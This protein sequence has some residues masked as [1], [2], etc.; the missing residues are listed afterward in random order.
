MPKKI[1]SKST[2]IG[3][4]N[5]LIKLLNGEIQPEESDLNQ[6]TDENG[7][8]LNNLQAVFLTTYGKITAD[9]E[10]I[11]TYENAFEANDNNGFY[12]DL[13]A[14]IGQ[15]N[16]IIE[17]YKE[18]DEEIEIIDNGRVINLKNVKISN[19]S[20]P[21]STSYY[22]QLILFIDQIIGFSIHSQD[23]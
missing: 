14:L 8:P 3:T 4:L 16:K 11:V 19:V 22:D 2:L 15:R 23:N 9:I 21:D 1:S 12:F 10:D 13:S 5:A 7:V 6:F 18:S 20:N 17:D